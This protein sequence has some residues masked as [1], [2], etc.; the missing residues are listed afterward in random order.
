MN[1]KD[2]REITNQLL[3]K[4]EDI[5]GDR[6]EM[7]A[8]KDRD[9]LHNFIEIAARKHITPEQACMNLCAKQEVARDDYIADISNGIQNTI[10]A[11]EEKIVDIINYHILLFALIRDRKANALPDSITI[12]NPNEKPKRQL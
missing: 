5:L 7:Y 9:R 11:W 6:A 10:P 8:G 2:F 12:V 3:E 1:H 4:C